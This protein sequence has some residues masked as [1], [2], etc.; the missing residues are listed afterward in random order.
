MSRLCGKQRPRLQGSSTPQLAAIMLAETETGSKPSPG[1]LQEMR[2]TEPSGV[3][4]GPAEVP[5]GGQELG[6]K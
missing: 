4:T 6:E 5:W 2:P 3:R 1:S